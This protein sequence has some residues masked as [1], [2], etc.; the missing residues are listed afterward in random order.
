MKEALNE[1]YLCLLRAILSAIIL[2]CSCLTSIRNPLTILPVI[3]IQKHT[4]RVNKQCEGITKERNLWH[5]ALKGE[6]Q[7]VNGSHI[8]YEKFEICH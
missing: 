8:S 1:R 7:Q 4:L 5:G 3:K 6:Y 2:R